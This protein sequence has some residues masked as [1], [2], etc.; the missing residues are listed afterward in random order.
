M[1]KKLNFKDTLPIVAAKNMQTSI[2]NPL[3]TRLKT[4]YSSLMILYQN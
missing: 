3:I 1:R 4:L 2:L